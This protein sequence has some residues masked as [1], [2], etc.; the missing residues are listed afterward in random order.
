M[1]L[2]ELT[3]TEL[4]KRKANVIG[5]IEEKK[6]ELQ[7]LATPPEGEPEEVDLLLEAIDMTEYY[8][9]NKL[10][11][12]MKS[13]E[14]AGE[15]LFYY[16]QPQSLNK[17]SKRLFDIAG[18]QY[19]VEQV[20]DGYRVSVHRNDKSR[21]SVY[22]TKGKDI[23]K[24]LPSITQQLALLSD[25]DFILDGMLIPFIS[26]RAQD[27]K[28]MEEH[29]KKQK[30]NNSVDV[31]F[32]AWDILYYNGI[33]LHDTRLYE[34]KKILNSLSFSAEGVRNIKEVP[35]LL[36]RDEE[37]LKHAIKIKLSA[38]ITL[39]AIIKEYE[40]SYPVNTL[41]DKWVVFGK[42]APKDENEGENIPEAEGGPEAA[43]A[44]NRSDGK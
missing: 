43:Q 10:F 14:K 25:T 8:T 6:R 1:N 18:R 42:N 29:V 31:G 24:K 23:T 41:S 19:Y 34:R 35:F 11:T 39:G 37:E 36:V 30:D 26:L 33:S 38:P 4:N 32:F 16:N 2:K 17:L 3:L 21:V 28:T 7:T 40:S 44:D 27:K 5:Y 9:P 12:P 22:T 15:T 20:F 13:T